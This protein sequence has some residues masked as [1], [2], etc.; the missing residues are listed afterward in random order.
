MSYQLLPNT[1][2]RPELSRHY[3]FDEQTL[4]QNLI[5]QAHCDEQADNIKSSLPN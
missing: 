4:V 5:E 1:T 2:I 3:R